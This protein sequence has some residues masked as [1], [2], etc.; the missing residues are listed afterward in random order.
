MNLFRIDFGE[1]YQRHL[2]RHSEFGLN[3]LHLVAVAGIYLSLFGIA[4]AL[5]G[6]TWIVAAALTAYTLVLARNIPFAL[7]LLNIASIAL[8]LLTY[9][10]LPPISVWIY[11]ALIVVWHRFQVWQHRIYRRHS[12]MRSFESR[13]KKGPRLAVLLAVYELPIL[14]NFLIFDRKSRT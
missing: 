2:C 6:A 10:L 5:P 13:Y 3:V 4:F 1:L 9:R 12:D 8:L 7:L 11:V 14:L